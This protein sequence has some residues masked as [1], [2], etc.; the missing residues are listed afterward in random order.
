MTLEPV[1][2]KLA[3]RRKEIARMG[4][5]RDE[6]YVFSKAPDSDPVGLLLK[7]ARKNILPSSS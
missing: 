1:I 3:R 6:K 5:Y 7:E 4:M 2:V